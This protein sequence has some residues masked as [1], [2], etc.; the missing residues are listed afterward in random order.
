MTPVAPALDYPLSPS[1]LKVLDK[2]PRLFRYT[3]LDRLLYPR[4]LSPQDQLAGQRG[5]YFHR[6]VELSQKGVPIEPLLAA[7]G[8]PLPQWW[9]V[10]MGSPHFR[11]P[12]EV[13]S[14]VSLWL[15]RRGVRFQGRLDRLVIAP[16]RQC[17]TIVDW[18]TERHRPSQDQLQESWQVRLYPLMLCLAGSTLNGG[19]PIAPERVRLTIWYVQHPQDPFELNYSRSQLQ[20]DLQALDQVIDHLYAYAENGYPR[21]TALDQCRHCWFATRCYGLIPEGLDPEIA[22]ALEGFV[23]PLDEE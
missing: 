7:A 5:D 12:G 3:Y 13:W 16:D 22:A 6:L 10:F 2:C 20:R 23:P 11:P 9:Q 1:S 14:E 18:K 4:E 8:D 19:Q 21:T 17:F 15:E